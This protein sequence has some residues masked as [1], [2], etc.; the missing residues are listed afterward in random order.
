M[1][2]ATD[3]MWRKEGLERGNGIFVYRATVTGNFTQHYR[4]Q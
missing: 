3:V 1:E 4:Q 2:F